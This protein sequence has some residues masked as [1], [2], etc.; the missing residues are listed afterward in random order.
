MLKADLGKWWSTWAPYWEHLEDRHLS[1]FVI[2]DFLKQISGPA[3]VVGAGQ[4]LTVEQLEKSG[5]QA[6]GIEL[7]REMI[8]RARQ[9]R[10][11]E[12]IQ[13]DAKALPFKNNHYQTVIIA[14]GVIDYIEDNRVIKDILDESLRVLRRYGKLL[15][16]FYQME[17]TVERVY[18]RIGVIGADKK[19]YLKRIFSI[20]KKLEERPMKCVELITSWTGRSY[21]N[22]FLYWMMLGL[23]LPQELRD[24]NRRIK[25]VFEMA[26]KEGVDSTYLYE[27][28]PD[29]VP[30]REEADIRALFGDMGVTDGEIAKYSDCIAFKFNKR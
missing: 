16:A 21:L 18:K 29:G 1:A 27:S 10:S 28:V 2:K 23:L 9:R 22:T 13:S 14:T 11:L 26:E 15:I 25:A 19:L 8:M 5:I 20:F 7:E 4:G 17:P 12:L 30:Y 6:D 3:L 24:E